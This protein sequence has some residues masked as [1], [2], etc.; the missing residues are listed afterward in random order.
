[1]QNSAPNKV[2]PTSAAVGP[3][4][5]AAELRALYGNP[6]FSPRMWTD[7]SDIAFIGITLIERSISLLA[8]ELRGELLDVGC[9]R[10]PYASYFQHLTRKRAC[11]FNS[12][13]GQVDFECPA[14]RIPLPDNSLD[15]ILCTEVLEH[16]PDPLAVWRE[17]H[18]LLRPGGKV[19]LATPMYWPGHEEPYDFYRYPEFGLRHLARESGFEILRLIPRGGAW[20]FFGQAGLHAMPQFI[21]FRWQRKLWN[22]LFLALDGWRCTPRMTIGWTVLAVRLP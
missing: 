10:Q 20:A 19:L 6:N 4:Q 16:V 22:K 2:P 14:D 5:K 1:L 3:A 9:G 13:R 12:K 15:S 18:R 8:P 21:R 7:A 11:D 17:F